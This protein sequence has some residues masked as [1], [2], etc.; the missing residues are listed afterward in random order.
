VPVLGAARGLVKPSLAASIEREFSKRDPVL[1]RA[2]VFELLHRGR[3]QALELHTERLSYM[4]RFIAVRVTPCA[5]ANPIFRYLSFMPELFPTRIRVTAMAI[6]Q[7][8]RTAVTAIVPAFIA[9]AVPPGTQHIPLIV[10]TITL[11]VCGVGA[12]GA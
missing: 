12:P 8:I 2:A 6:H 4:T 10:G 11:I 3:I 9:A 5:A 7:N 1:V